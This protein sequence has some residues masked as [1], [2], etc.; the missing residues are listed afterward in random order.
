LREILIKDRP[1]IPSI[2]IVTMLFVFATGG[3]GHFSTIGLEVH[4]QRSSQCDG[5]VI[6]LADCS[7]STSSSP[8]SG[9]SS[10]SDDNDENDNN[11]G[12]N[13]KSD[14]SEDQKDENNDGNIE[15][16]IPSTAGGGVPF[17]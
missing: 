3:L 2:F 4:A 12:D 1:R 16:K 8:S 5:V 15:A 6:S 7:P 14:N 9:D 13:D 17:P 11:E 10:A